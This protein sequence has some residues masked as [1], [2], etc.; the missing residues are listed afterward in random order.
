M[1]FSTILF[2]YMIVSVLLSKNSGIILGINLSI[3]FFFAGK[4]IQK[5][6]L[7]SK[8]LWFL[9]IPIGWALFYGIVFHDNYL[10]FKDCF[11]LST[12]L[13]FILIGMIFARKLPFRTFIKSFIFF[14]T[15]SGLVFIADSFIQYGFEALL[16]PRDAGYTNA[17]FGRSM[18]LASCLACVI[19]TGLHFFSKLRIPKRKSWFYFS[20]LINILCVYMSG[21]RTII[22]SLGVSLCIMFYYIVKRHLMIGVIGGGV[23]L[24]AAI[25]LT[26]SDSSLAQ[27]FTRSGSEIGVRDYATQADI[28]TNYRGW[29]AYQALKT[30]KKG[31]L[32]ELL[33]GHGAGK[34]IALDVVVIG[35]FEAIPILHNGYYYLLVKI[36]PIGMLFYLLFYF[37]SI[38]YARKL[39]LSKPTDA[40]NFYYRI[41]LAIVAVILVTHIS[42]STITNPEY[43]LCSLVLGAMLQYMYKDA[44]ANS[45]SR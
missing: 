38:K 24:L 26:S 42:V 1:K 39:K 34:L 7:L 35:D 17:F 9:L 20:I 3:I 40:S 33:F 4:V 27:A 37:N 2:I 18:I 43:G 45:I 30:Y 6:K 31:N 15:A 25:A 41:A 13:I 22:L 23:F 8:L 21:S 12:P 32:Y 36:G 5:N 29:E 19:L 44:R 14:A 11:Y 28:N 10:V 16:D